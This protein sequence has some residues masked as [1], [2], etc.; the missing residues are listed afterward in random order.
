MVYGAGVS[1]EE[2]NE[3]SVCIAVI[4]DLYVEDLQPREAWIFKVPGTISVDDVKSLYTSPT[5][6]SPLYVLE[7]R[8]TDFNWGASAS[9]IQ[10][11]IQIAQELPH[12]LLV[13]GL[14]LIG[15]K[16]RQ[17]LSKE[18][19]TELTKPLDREDAGWAATYAI[20]MAYSYVSRDSLRVLKEEHTLNPATY[21]LTYEDEHHTYVAEVQQSPSGIVVTRV[22]R[23]TT[24]A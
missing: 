11:L 15:E 2:V 10:Y 7:R 1:E 16:I 24:T 6:L 22:T 5:G 23:I 8:Y 9:S 21:I 14:G 20:A 19:D 13:A 12:D 4:D 3:S 17:K 18:R